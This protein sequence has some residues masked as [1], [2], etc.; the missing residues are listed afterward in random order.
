MHLVRI[1]MDKNKRETK[2]ESDMKNL[3]LDWELEE[4]FN[5][6][7]WGVQTSAKACMFY[8]NGSITSK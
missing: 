6:S 2:Q 5:K 4:R 8:G 1:Q 3:E 7:T